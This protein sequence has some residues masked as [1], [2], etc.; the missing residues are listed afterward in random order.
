M[1][2]SRGGSS[3]GGGGD[4]PPAVTSDPCGDVIPDINSFQ[5]GDTAIAVRD[6]RI[7]RNVVV[8]QG[9]RGCVVEPASS[10]RRICVQFEQR[11]DFSDNRLNCLPD[12]LRHILVGGLYI[13]TR[14]RAAR[15]LDASRAHGIAPGTPGKR[16]GSW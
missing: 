6:L 9:G 4:A 15:L 12:E 16:G 13:G 1:S 7:R 11:G 5:C 8:R 3:G 14:V 2:F 10:T